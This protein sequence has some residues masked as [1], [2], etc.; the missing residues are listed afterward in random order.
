MSSRPVKS[1]FLIRPV[2]KDQYT[3]PCVFCDHG[4][5]IATL[6]RVTEV[7]MESKLRYVFYVYFSSTDKIELTFERKLEAI[8]AQRELLR[9]WTQTGEFAPQENEEDND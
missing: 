8:A 1:A 3:A 6:H 5:D 2:W 7:Y 9:A 4:F